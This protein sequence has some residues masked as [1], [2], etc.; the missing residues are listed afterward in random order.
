MTEL[1]RRIEDAADADPDE[2]ARRGIELLL[3]GVRASLE[4]FRVRMDH[5]FLEHT[6]H[7]TGAIDE[8]LERLERE[9]ALYEH[10]GALWMRTTSWG[11]DKD[12]VLRRSNGDTPTS[13]RTSR[14][15][16]TSAAASTTARSTYGG[17][18]TT[19][20]STGCAPPGRP[21]AAIRTRSRS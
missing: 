4:R 21:S 1:A 13:P 6:L 14:I 20:T 15:T 16:C 3:E 2:L 5:F 19:A 8:A 12:R 9:G 10:E 17:P 7:E 18:T 11:D